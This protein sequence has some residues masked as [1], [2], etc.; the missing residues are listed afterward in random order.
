MLKQLVPILSIAAE[1]RILSHRQA[2]R[3]EESWRASG[4]EAVI[5]RPNKDGSVRE[6]KLV[7]Q[8][9]LVVVSAGSINTPLILKRSGFQNSWIGK[10]LRIHPVCGL[11]GYFPQDVTP[12]SGAMM[13]AVVNAVDNPTG[14]HYGAKLE[15]PFI[16]TAFQAVITQWTGGRSHK[17][18][19]LDINKRMSIISLCRDT[20]SG[21]VSEDAQGRPEVQYF[22]NDRDEASLL[23]GQRTAAQI[24]IAAGATRLGSTTHGIPTIDV[25]PSKGLNDPELQSWLAQ[26]AEAGIEPARTMVVSAHQMGTARMSI[27]PSQGSTRPTGQ[28]WESDNVFICDTSLFPTPAGS[29]PMVTTYAVAHLV[30]QYAKPRLARL[31][32][33]THNKLHTGRL[34]GIQ[35]HAAL[36]KILDANFRSLNICIRHVL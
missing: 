34:Q 27:S 20:G 13:T 32:R 19:M 14:D 30:A 21:S 10:N 8:A 11:Y 4:V 3:V 15:C 33:E 17:A 25:D 16:H 12:H 23:L 35:S 31:K 36:I 9:N 28:T 22:L 6:I 1:S 5:S 24:L 7:V 2:G 26:I 29:N 18:E